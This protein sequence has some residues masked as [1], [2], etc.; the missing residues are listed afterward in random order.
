MYQTNFRREIKWTEIL[1]IT[2]I[3]TTQTETQTTTITTTQTET[4]T[5]I[6]TATTAITTITQTTIANRKEEPRKEVPFF[7]T[8]S[9]VT[10]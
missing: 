7:L 4:Q 5:T 1:T 3:T 8:V 6:T 9:F 10:R 2:T